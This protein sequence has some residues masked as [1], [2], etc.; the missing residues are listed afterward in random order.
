MTLDGI[1]LGL[2]NNYVKASSNYRRKK[3]DTTNFTIISN[4]CWGGIVYE[5]YGLPKQTPTVGMFFM[6]EEYLKFVSNLRHYVEDC[7]MIF[8][9]PDQARHK[10]YYMNDKRF[11]SYPIARLDDVEIAMLHFHSR[12]EAAF[13][14]KSRCERINWES[15]LVKM[16]DQNVCKK[17]HAEQFMKLPFKNKVFFTV[18]KDWIDI[19]GITVLKSKNT[20]CCGVLDEPFGASTMFN[21]NKLINKI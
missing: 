8:V 13:K 9:E 5:S 6:A 16:N 1:L 3:L 12:E 19:H 10:N 15:M 20:N 11:G 2:R 4:N 7:E 21:V 18:K 17:E 14:W